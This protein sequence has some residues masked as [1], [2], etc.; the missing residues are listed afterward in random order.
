MT[1]TYEEWR[2]MSPRMRAFYTWPKEALE[3]LDKYGERK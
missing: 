3:I 2:R 1:P